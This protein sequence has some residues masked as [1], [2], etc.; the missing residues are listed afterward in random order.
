[1]P[2]RIDGRAAAMS[3][4][5][6]SRYMAPAYALVISF[7]LVLLLGYVLRGQGTDGTTGPTTEPPTHSA[8]PTITRMHR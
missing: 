4:G 8:P 6:R 3:D 2:E 7:A 5:W 1:V